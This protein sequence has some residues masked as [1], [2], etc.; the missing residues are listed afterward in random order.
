MLIKKFPQILI[1]LLILLFSGCLNYE[2]VATI[3]KNG[4]GEMFIHYWTKMS[5]L[6]DSL[7]LLSTGIFNKDTLAVK[8]SSKFT[9]IDYTEVYKDFSDSTVHA[10]VKFIFS[11]IDSLNLIPAFKNYNFTFEEIND[12]EYKFSQDINYFQFSPDSTDNYK[13]SFTY[14]L[15]GKIL[16]HNANSASLNKLVWEFDLNEAENIKQ[17][18]ATFEPF[19]LNETPRWVYYSGIF[20]FLVVLYFLFRFKKN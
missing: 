1:I 17:L 5:Q 12:D 15:P 19:R 16:S 6:P 10:K 11:D 14:Y 18:T 4:S 7:L 2:Q 3:K 8:Y 13:M 9:T 20:V